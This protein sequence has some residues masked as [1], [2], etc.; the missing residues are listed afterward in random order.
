[1]TYPVIGEIFELTLDGTATKNQPLEMVHADGFNVQN[2]NHKG[3]VVRQRETRRFKL[4]E[5]GYCKNLDEVMSKLA[6]HGRIPPGQWREAFKVRYR[7]SRRP[8]GIADA[9]WVDP[10]N[11]A[12]FPCI[13]A[14][15]GLGFC[16]PS[17][18]FDTNWQWLV[19]YD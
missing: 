4:V 3:P 18:Q 9:S 11:R 5:V 16:G 19:I 8:V 10:M 13:Y 1:M 17:Y 15:G 12:E 7:Y 6:V 2:W 14:E